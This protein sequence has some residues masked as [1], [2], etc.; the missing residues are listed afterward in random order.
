MLHV[1]S[2]MLFG[3]IAGFIAS[4]IVNAHGQGCIVNIVLGIVGAVVGG[5]IFH[6]LG[7]QDQQ[8]FLWSLFTAVIGAIVV[9]FLW[10]AATG[11]RT[12]R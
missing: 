2:W 4:K 1:I 5:A 10:Q 3:L 11:K 8:G 6:F 9:L 7:A 12:L